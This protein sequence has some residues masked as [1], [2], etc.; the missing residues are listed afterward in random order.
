MPMHPKI[1]II[2]GASSGLGKLTAL[3]LA[4]DGWTIFNYSLTPPE[5]QASMEARGVHYV[6][7]DIT[8]PDDVYQAAQQMDDLGISVLINNAGIN[9]INWL[10]HVSVEMWDDVMNTNARAIML[11]SQV[12][13]DKLTQSKGTILN[14]ISNAAHIPMTASIAYNASKAAA[15]IMTLQMAREL[16]KQ[17][18]ITVFGIAPNKLAGTGMSHYIE[19]RVTEVRGWTPEYAAQYQTAALVTGE[20]TEPVMIADLI[21]YL[22]GEKK[23]HKYLSGCIL[24]YGA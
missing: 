9:E 24:P 6:R 22:L 19:Q 1:A 7:C 21:T 2:T 3:L 12:F 15:H 17:R 11:M 14:I 20:E 13:L 16:T 8:S 23:R 18:G 5:D 10:P 4:A